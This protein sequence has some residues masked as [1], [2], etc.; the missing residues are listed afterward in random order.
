MT[1]GKVKLS[2]ITLGIMT[3]S[4]MTLGIMTL[5]IM[6]LGIVTLGIITLSIMTLRPIT[7]GI[8]GLLATLSIT[9]LCI[10]CHYAECRSSFIVILNVIMLIFV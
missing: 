9:T 2:K 8:K 4:I 3:L 6:T 7:F 5:L 10:K 1:I